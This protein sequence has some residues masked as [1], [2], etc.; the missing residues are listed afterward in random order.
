M[1]ISVSLSMNQSMNAEGSF[2]GAGMEIRQE[3]ILVSIA[4]ELNE[5]SFRQLRFESLNA[6]FRK[7]SEGFEIFDIEGE[8]LPLMRFNGGNVKILADGQLEGL[9]KVGVSAA[10]FKGVGSVKPPYFAK[11]EDDHF[12]A[13]LIIS[14]S[15]DRPRAE[16]VSVG[17]EPGPSSSEKEKSS[18]TLKNTGL[19]PGSDG[20]ARALEDNFNRLIESKP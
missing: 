12:W 5:V 20:R 3:P 9:L 13:D 19:E 2:E 7:S 18:E 11:N 8:S 16:F 1:D 6:S 10:I 4:K 17:N 15:I 14:G